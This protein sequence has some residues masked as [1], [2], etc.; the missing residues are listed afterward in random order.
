MVRN[1]ILSTGGVVLLLPLLLYSYT[2]KGL[3]F[4]YIV[5]DNVYLLNIKDYGSIIDISPFFRY[6]GFF[7]FMYNG[8]VSL[9]NFD[10]NNIFLTNNLSLQKKFYLT[11]VGNKNITYVNLYSFLPASRDIYKYTEFILGN[12]L[13]IY[14]A[15]KYLFAPDVN[16]KYKNFSSD[17]MSDYLEPNIKSSIKIPLPYFFF[18][19]E[20]GAGMKMYDNEALLFYTILSHFDFPLNLNFS[21]A[22]SLSYLHTQHPEDVYP[23]DAAYADD[24]FFEQENLSHMSD[25]TLLVNKVFLK[26]YSQLSLDVQIFEKEFFEVDNQGRNDNGLKASVAFTKFIKRNLSF[27]VQFE[28][29]FNSSSLDDFDYNKNNLVLSFQL[30]F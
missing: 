12:S 10:D 1:K 15:D 23:I 19:P 6:E 11:G 17:S 29:L 18:I 25:I 2:N 4:S 22:L 24:P 20:I 3:S 14:V 28:S 8:N 30:I 16:L 21:A 13:N 9:I 5:S 7:S 26:Q 27:S